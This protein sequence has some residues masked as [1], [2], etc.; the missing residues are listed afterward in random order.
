MA[1]EMYSSLSLFLLW[2]VTRLDIVGHE[3]RGSEVAQTAKK[4]S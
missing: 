2:F 3:T 1:A 4:G